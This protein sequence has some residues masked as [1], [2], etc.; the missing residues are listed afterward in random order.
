V[1]ISILEYEFKNHKRKEVVLSQRMMKE[2]GKIEWF[3]EVDRKN[4]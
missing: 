3:C 1:L 2:M 4:N